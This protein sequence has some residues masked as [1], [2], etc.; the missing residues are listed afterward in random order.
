LFM[1]QPKGPSSG[2][3]LG[4]QYF[5]P[6]VGASITNE[7]GRRWYSVDLWTAKTPRCGGVHAAE[8]GAFEE[9]AAGGVVDDRIE[10]S[11]S[12]LLDILHFTDG[13]FA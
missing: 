12:P 4:A 8:A 9:D 13:F 2:V 3:L 7:A 1:L 11:P 6:Q 10:R 5:D